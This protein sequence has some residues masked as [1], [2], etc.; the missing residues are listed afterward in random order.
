MRFFRRIPK[1]L[2]NKYVIAT[3]IFLIYT[4]IFD[5]NNISSQV[6]MS[7]Q[8]K[9]MKTERDF[10]LT[11]IEKDSIALKDLASQTGNLERYAREE[12][13]MKKDNEDI[14]IL[15]GDDFEQLKKE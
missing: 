15:I 2:Y 12:Y 4:L 10:Y 11:E 1:I 3:V 8:L 7:R 14:F 9:K 13:L 5:V 6:K